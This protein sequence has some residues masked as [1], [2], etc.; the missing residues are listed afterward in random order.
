MKSRKEREMGHITLNGK[1]ESNTISSSLILKRRE[2][3]AG[4]GAL[5]I[6]IVS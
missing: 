6:V 2:N 5:I 3:S 4:L 1:C